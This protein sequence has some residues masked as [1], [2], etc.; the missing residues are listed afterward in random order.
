MTTT[1][2]KIAFLAAALSLS[3]CSWLHG[4]REFEPIT[5]DTTGVSGGVDYS[6]LD[7]VLKAAVNSGGEIS[8]DELMDNTRMLEGQLMLLALSGP[9]T[10]PELFEDEPAILNYWLNARAAW[11]LKLMLT[12]SREHLKDG[13]KEIRDSDRWQFGKNGISIEEFSNRPFPIDGRSMTLGLIDELLTGEFGFRA[14]AGAPCVS[15]LRA[16]L[17]T[18]PFNTQDVAALIDKRF[19]QFVDD[20]ERFAVDIESR[21]ILIPPVLWR[22]REEIIESHEKK[23]G[24]TGADL[25]TALLPYV[26]FSPHRRLQDAV[27]YKCVEASEKKV[28]LI[29]KRKD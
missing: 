26:Q 10:Q 29:I 5:L 21:R 3:G 15:P 7:K 19:G 11:S 24:S 23:Y 28:A 22:F 12:F 14:V 4:T 27:G 8:P 2:L 17:P 20:S 25:A 16:K 13:D 1:R 9:K 18:Q 6:G